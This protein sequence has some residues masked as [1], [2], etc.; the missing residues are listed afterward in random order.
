MHTFLIENLEKYLF[1]VKETNFI[2]TSV[3]KVET[4][5]EH[6]RNIPNFGREQ[7][8][9]DLDMSKSLHIA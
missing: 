6:S 5:V 1:E 4:K 9:C 2:K 7:V 8:F 3:E